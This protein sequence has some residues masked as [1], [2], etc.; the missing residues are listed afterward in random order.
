MKKIVSIALALVLVL[1]CFSAVAEGFVPAESYEVGERAL[2]GGNVHM[3]TAAQGGGDINTVRYAGIEGQDY[4]DE[5]VYTYKDFTGSLTSSSDWNPHTWETADD[6]NLLAML[7]TGFYE[8][9][10]N[11]D[12]KGY[13]I[14]P[15]MA[16]EYPVDVTAEYVGK[17]G[18]AEG[19][20]AKAFRIA[21][22]QAATWENGDKIT[23]DDYIYSMQQLLN[24]KMLNRRADTFYAGSF[25][26]VGA[27]DYLYSAQA[28]QTAYNTLTVGATEALANGA[29]LYIDMWGMWGMEGCVDAEGNPCPQYWSINDETLYRDAAVAEGSAEDWVSGKYMYET[30]LQDGAPYASYQTTYMAQSYI[31]EG[32][33]WEEVGLV[34]VDDYTIDIIYS[35][36]IAEATFYVPYSLSQW[37]VYKPLYEECKSFF[38][39]DG[40]EVETEEEAATVT[41]NYCKSLETSIGYGPY[42]L[43][44]FELDKEYTFVRNENWYGYHDGKHLG[45]YQTDVYTVSVI[46][47]HKAAM[48][49]FEKG[50]L[51]G[52]TL[53]ATDMEKY[54]SS[55]YI[56]YTPQSYTTK[57]TFNTDYEKLLSRG[58]N[59]QILAVDEF[60]Q[61]FALAIDREH[62]ATSFTAS[63]RPGHGILNYMYVYDPFTG[64]SYRDN[65]AAKVALVET[66]GL[67]YGEGGDYATLDEAYAAM[68]GYDMEG[69]KAAMK[70][71]GEK[72]ITAGIWDG[73]APIEI[74]FRVYQSDDIYVQMFTYFDTQ[75]KEACVGSALEGKVSLKMT[76]DPDY[77]ETNY[78]GGA[79]MIFTTWGGSTMDPF[80]TFY[81]CYADASDGSGQQMEYGF[82]T[83][84]VALTFN[85]DGEE[86]TAS[87]QEWAAWGNSM[88]VPALNEKYGMFNNYSYDTRCQIMAGVE[89][90]LLAYYTTTPIYYRNV[91][92]LYSM[93]VNTAVKD[94]QQLVGFGGMAFMTYNYDDTAWAEYCANNTLA[95]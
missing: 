81:Q 34:K 31:I 38:D 42:T 16:A 73:V 67:T 53:D 11:E 85:I 83:S 43:G 89:K 2:F 78:S 25:A 46:A 70:I 92:S 87:L 40:K 94:Y 74:E 19:E 90:G 51:V 77:Y 72:A 7:Q 47:E 23:A 91:A 3:E 58:T 45:M 80:S 27:K 49:A 24:P 22:N 59:S 12:G 84:K 86:V 71:A 75:V 26:V 17:F 8:F 95:Y 48:M 18:V 66:Y 1:S 76:V 21:L 57:L 13:A 61:G 50:D 56:Y 69:A 14:V 5:K 37:L 39:A 33:T 41:T 4:T 28:G 63:H 55:D 29:D 15:E 6:S 82:D 62:F 32:G 36:P 60:R 20:S 10:L 35:Q 64:A 68:T 54:A 30:Y 52:V 93:Q 65:E 88:D 79:D 44:Y 9:Y